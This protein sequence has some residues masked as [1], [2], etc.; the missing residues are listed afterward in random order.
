VYILSG[1]VVEFR[2][3]RIKVRH[4]GY[5]IAETYGDIKAMLDGLDEGERDKLAADGWSFLNINDKIITSGTELHEGK[6]IS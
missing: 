3:I 6:V 1:N 4:E 2:K 5:I